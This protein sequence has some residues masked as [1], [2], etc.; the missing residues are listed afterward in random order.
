[1]TSIELL[2]ANKYGDRRN[3]P[4]CSRLRAV[5]IL[6]AIFAIVNLVW[7][8]F[9][10]S[11]RIAMMQSIEGQEQ[12]WSA[13]VPLV[14]ASE[15][16]AQRELQMQQMA[17]IVNTTDQQ[18]RQLARCY[19]DQQFVHP[20]ANLSNTHKL[21]GPAMNS[22]R[23]I[24]SVT[25][26]VLIDIKNPCSGTGGRNQTVVVFLFCS[27]GDWHRRH[28]IRETYGKALKQFSQTEIYFVVGSSNDIT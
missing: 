9:N 12:S 5:V 1:M 14:N 22:I 28:A 20:N 13:S 17:G 10:N 3:W 26:D 25:D 19:T 15:Y 11:N 6:L 21:T 27:P 2:F 24:A 7:Y 18:L 8:L 23:E 4:R 16:L